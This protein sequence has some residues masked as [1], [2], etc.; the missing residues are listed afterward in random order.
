M[1]Q[2][3]A[4]HVISEEN[5]DFE[6]SPMVAPCACTRQNAMTRAGDPER[7]KYASQKD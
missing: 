2:D 3:I 7:L 6:V 4:P 1:R 5:E